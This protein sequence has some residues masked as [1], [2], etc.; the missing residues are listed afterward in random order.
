MRAF[1]LSI[2]K[3]GWPD[4]AINAFF[5]GAHAV[6]AWSLA[7]LIAAHIAAVVLHALQG[8][9]VLHRMLPGPRPDR[10]SIAAV[11]FRHTCSILEQAYD[12]S[13][14]PE[15]RRE[16]ARIF[17]AIAQQIMLRSPS[18]SPQTR[19]AASSA[20]HSSS[21]NSRELAWKAMPSGPSSEKLSP[22]P[23]RASMIS[24]VCLA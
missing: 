15:P 4:E 17:R 9:T 14:F 18:N 24:W 10:A 16:G 21:V 11:S 22:T 12:P 20:A 2:P 19:P 8:R 23:G 7:A 6:L 13:S 5:N 1:G 3:A